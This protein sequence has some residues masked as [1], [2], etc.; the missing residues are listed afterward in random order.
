MGVTINHRLGAK[1]NCVKAMLDSTE[2]LAEQIK[3]V[4]EKIDVKIVVRRLAEETLFIDIG[5][6]E[7]LAFDFKTVSML[8]AD[9]Q[10]DGWSYEWATLTDDGKKELDAGYEIKKFPQNEIVYSSDFCKTQFSKTRI[11]HKF[12]ADLIKSVAI[13]CRSAEVNDEGDYYYT[14]DLKD[15]EDAISENG[16]VIDSM[17]ERLQDLGY[18]TP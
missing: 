2:K 9:Y 3:E 1:R 15:A 4:G 16:K 10:K 13:R 5:N 7:T 11:E 17:M 12:V 6:C 14:N 8:N 18:K